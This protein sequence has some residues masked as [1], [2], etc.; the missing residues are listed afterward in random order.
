MPTRD[1]PTSPASHHNLPPLQHQR[2][3]RRR[4][5]PPSASAPSSSTPWPGREERSDWSGCRLEPRLR[6]VRVVGVVGVVRVV[7]VGG[8]C[9][10]VAEGRIPQPDTVRPSPSHIHILP[11]LRLQRRP[12]HP[13]FTQHN[14]KPQTTNNCT[15]QWRTPQCPQTHLARTNR[16]D[17]ANTRAHAP[18]TNIFVVFLVD[19]LRSPTFFS[20]FT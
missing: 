7:G 19:R 12:R 11:L 18:T 16:P 20:P 9:A 1:T 10:C 15:A 13:H 3:P 8:G 2:R 17:R 6:V 5:P 14:H 4:P